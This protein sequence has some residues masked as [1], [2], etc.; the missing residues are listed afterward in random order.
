MIE[1]MSLPFN[2]KFERQNINLEKMDNFAFN[3]CKN[4]KKENLL[5]KAPFKRNFLGNTFFLND[6]YI[7]IIKVQTM[8]EGHTLWKKRNFWLVEEL[9]K[10]MWS[11]QKT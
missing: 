1:Q 7:E 11:F 9:F 5:I 3:I 2:Q 4:T 8:W 10:F 6:S